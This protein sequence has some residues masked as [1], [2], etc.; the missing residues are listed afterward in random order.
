MKILT[1]F[2]LYVTCAS[3]DKEIKAIFFQNIFNTA[4]VYVMIND[5]LQKLI[6]KKRYY[7]SVIYVVNFS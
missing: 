5:S 3:T 6:E 7:F 1:N 2:I 4:V